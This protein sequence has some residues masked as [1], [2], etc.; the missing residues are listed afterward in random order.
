MKKIVLGLIIFCSSIFA[1]KITIFAA[2]DLKFALD[3]IRKEF[4][5]EYKNNEIEMI[6]GS[7]GK[8]MHQIENGAPFDIFFSANMGFIEKLYKQGDVTSKPKMYALGRI[9]IWSNNKSF[10]S[11]KGFENLKEPWVKKIAIANPTHAP[12]G[13][14]AKQAMESLN[15]Y[16]TLKSKFVL[17]ENISQTAAFIESGAAD[18]GVI[19]LSLVLAPNIA[20]DK[21]NSYYLIDDKLHEPLEQGYGIT[22][23]GSKK[24][25]SQKFYDFMETSN[26]N[27]IMKKYGF[28]K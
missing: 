3:D 2:S 21:F 24:E 25:L 22:K 18:V 19:A 28:M 13:E 10:D 12:Y 17:G 20:N 15:I 6:Y 1:D 7:S 14:K 9:V 26:A 16:N 5:K 8:G 4:L 23:I 11:S 27:E